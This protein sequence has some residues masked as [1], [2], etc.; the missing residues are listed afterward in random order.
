MMTSN[1]DMFSSVDNMTAAMEVFEQD[2]E[3]LLELTYPVGP[4]KERHIRQASV[5]VRRWLCDNDLRKLFPGMTDRVTVPVLEDGAWLARVKEDIE[6]DYY[7]SAGV[8]FGRGVVWSLYHSQAEEVPDWVSN[9][10]SPEIKHE[11]LGRA[12]NKTALYFRGDVFPMHE[13]LRYACNKLGGAHLDPSRSER[14]M[15]L[16]DAASFLTFGP[17]KAS[18]SNGRAGKVHLEYEDEGADILSGVAVTVIV[19]AS[20][21]VNLHFDGERIVILNT[22]SAD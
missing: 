5:I 1:Q 12:L 6:T 22:G 14:Q 10:A 9:M 11:K 16:D 13:V 18:I 4:V 19:A 7:L 21:L 2:I 8:R 20:M 15:K 17:P 3:S